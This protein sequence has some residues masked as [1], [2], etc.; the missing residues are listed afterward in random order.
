M[1]RRILHQTW[2]DTAIPSAFACY[3]EGWKRLHPG[4]DFKLWTDADLAE[5]VESRCAEHRELFHA[6]AK[7]IMRADLRT[8]FLPAPPDVVRYATYDP[9]FLDLA[10]AAYRAMP[11]VALQACDIVREKTGKP[12]LLEVNPGGGTWMFS[13]P[14][15][16]P[17]YRTHLGTDDLTAEFDAFRTCAR[18]LIERTR[19]EAI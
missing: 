19:A 9:C 13:S 8:D 2:K 16:A 10:A 11:D 18:V 4:W 17:S 15:N 6:Y 7:P 12:Y 3:M 14:N 5:F 1:I